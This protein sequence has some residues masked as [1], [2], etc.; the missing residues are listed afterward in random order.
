[1]EDVLGL[2]L[3]VAGYAV[4]SALSALVLVVLVSIGLAT[5]VW[6]ALHARFGH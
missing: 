5:S 1:M 3:T 4:A 2:V 6:D